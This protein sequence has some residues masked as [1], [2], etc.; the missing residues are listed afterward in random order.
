ME[1]EIICID[2]DLCDGCGDCIPNCHEG[3]LQLIDGKARLIS[4][5]L[6]DGLGACVGHCPQG[7]IN[8]EKRVA[9]PYNETEVIKLMASKGR[10]TVLAHLQHLLDHNEIDF[11]KE[12]VGWLRKNEDKLDFNL[13]E[14]TSIIHNQKVERERMKIVSMATAMKPS[15]N[16]CP[17]SQTREIDPINGSVGEIPSR[18]S[19]ELKQWPVQFHLVN[20]SA[21]YFQGADLLLA[22]DCSA[23]T[24]GN[25]HSDYLKGKSLIIGCPKLDS[26]QENYLSKLVHLIDQAQIN[27]IHVLVMEVPCCGGL[28]RLVEQATT[29]ATRKV[30]VKATVVGVNGA[31]LSEEWV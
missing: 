11:L 30:P 28:I 5:L 29:L 9:D 31:V 21:G 16:G 18:Q 17:G 20:P 19:S 15:E 22:A 8:M 27:T 13:Q 3:A 24:L 12:G 7:A 4:D 10:N 2:E 26:G 6:C 23:Y 14:V 25:F 1:R